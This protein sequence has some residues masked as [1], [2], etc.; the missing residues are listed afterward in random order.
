[1]TVSKRGSEGFESSDVSGQLE[2]TKDPENP[3]DLSSL[4][5]ILEGVLGGEEGQGQGQVEG[6]DPQ[7]VD[8]VQEG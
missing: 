4:R 5:Y 6:Q 7:Q 3:E 8:H 1:M 2:D